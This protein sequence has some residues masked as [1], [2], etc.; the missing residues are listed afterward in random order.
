MEKDI[1]LI[2][3][4]GN[5]ILLEY[6]YGRDLNYYAIPTIKINTLNNIEDN[7]KAQTNTQYGFE[8]VLSKQLYS[9]DVSI[10][11]E[12]YI[13]HKIENDIL[14]YDMKWQ[15]MKTALKRNYDDINNVFFK[16]YLSSCI[17]DE[18]K[19]QFGVKNGKIVYISEVAD[20]D[21][22]LACGC[23]CPVCGTKL[24]ARIGYGKR[25]P[26]FAHNNPGCNTNVAQQTALHMLAKEILMETN[27]IRLP[28]YTLDGEE[29]GYI[30]SGLD[31]E[32]ERKL[33]Q[34]FEYKSAIDFSFDKIV[35]EKRIDDIIP[36][37]IIGRRRV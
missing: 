26:Y 35:L 2:I 6:K 30:D 14:H 32:T 4:S 23:F 21:R 33:R 15:T 37:I 18:I 31:Y 5:K 22:G 9:D 17:G 36:D 3:K 29:G 24:Q 28:A 7:I 25:R 27:H 19:L 1:I 34:P 20:K 8:I 16:E 13:P 10:W 11:Y 12:A